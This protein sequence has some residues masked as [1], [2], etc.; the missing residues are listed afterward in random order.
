[1]PY[2]GFVWICVF[3]FFIEQIKVRVLGEDSF[4]FDYKILADPYVKVDYELLQ[5]YSSIVPLIV[6]ALL[7]IFILLPIQIFCKKDLAQEWDEEDLGKVYSTLV[8]KFPTDYDKENP[9]TK[10]EGNR[11]LLE[12]QIYEAEQ[13]GEL[14]K[15]RILES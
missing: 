11:R 3:V 7:A 5:K 6:L 4:L 9:F 12:I 10:K 13:E 14:H 8:T 15:I 1:M 2:I